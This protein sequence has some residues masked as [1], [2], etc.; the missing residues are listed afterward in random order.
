MT[1]TTCPYCAEE[2]Q[3]SSERCPYC[4]SLFSTTGQQWYRSAKGKMVAGVC[5]GL[6]EHFQLP[7]IAFRLAFAIATVLGGWGLFIYI[8]LWLLM[9]LK[10]D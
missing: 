5:R 9:P 10:E 7:A 8:C 3:E 6:A 4:L 2:I 1:H